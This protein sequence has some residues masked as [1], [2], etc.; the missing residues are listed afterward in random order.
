M[1]GVLSVGVSAIADAVCDRIFNV[2][3]KILV[4]RDFVIRTGL[5]GLNSSCIYAYTYI[6]IK[7]KES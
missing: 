7:E 5:T 1:D 6:H 4:I 2:L 3:P